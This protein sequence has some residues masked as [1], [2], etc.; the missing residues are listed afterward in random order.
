[1]P[2]LAPVTNTD[3]FSRSSIRSMALDHDRRLRVV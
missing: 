1:M 2:V 3:L